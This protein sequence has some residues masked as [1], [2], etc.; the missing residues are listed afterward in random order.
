VASGLDEPVI[1][2]FWLR[3]HFSKLK[4]VTLTWIYDLGR[5]RKASAEAVGA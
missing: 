2:V 1:R 5:E 4:T 3:V